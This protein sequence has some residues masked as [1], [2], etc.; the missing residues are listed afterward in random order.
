MQQTGDAGNALALFGSLF[1]QIR[2]PA[3]PAPPLAAPAIEGVIRS[4]PGDVHAKRAA[5]AS[6]M[7]M[8]S[9]LTVDHT[10]RL[11]EAL[12]PASVSSTDAQTAGDAASTAGQALAAAAP[13][14]AGSAEL[15][16]SQPN[17][18]STN[19]RIVF[20]SLLLLV[21]LLALIF[22]F[23][24]SSSGTAVYVALAVLGG[25]AWLGVVLFVMGYQ[26]VDVKASTGQDSSSSSGGSD[27]SGSGAPAGSGSGA[28]AGQQH[29]PR[30]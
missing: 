8:H 14:L 17:P 20:S 25:L 7:A 27:G 22:V 23:V 18:L 6:H 21:T 24:A 9:S 11:A 16:L 4:T 10:A 29:G 28:A 26:T 15:S 30:K 13:T 2:P 1:D 19:Y 12:V 5:V 3:R